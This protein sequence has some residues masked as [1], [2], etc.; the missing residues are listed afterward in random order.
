MAPTESTTKCN[1]ASSSYWYF[2][3]FALPKKNVDL[4][5]MSYF[6]DDEKIELPFVCFFQ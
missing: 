5:V 2:V 6:F 1:F 3:D 4:N